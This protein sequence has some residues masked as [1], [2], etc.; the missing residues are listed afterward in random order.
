MLGD[1]DGDE[2]AKAHSS[3]L[4]THSV[5]LLDPISAKL[6]GAKRRKSVMEELEALIFNSNDT[7]TGMDKGKHCK[8]NRRNQ[9]L[10]Q[11]M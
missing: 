3:G 9:L 2:F 5:R 6:L 11:S 8:E 4:S 1:I 7:V 10:K